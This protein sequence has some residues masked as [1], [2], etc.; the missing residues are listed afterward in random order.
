MSDSQVRPVPLQFGCPFLECVRW[1]CRIAGSVLWQGL[2]RWGRNPKAFLCCQHHNPALWFLYQ[3]DLATAASKPFSFHNFLKGLNYISFPPALP[4]SYD[5]KGRRNG[6]CFSV[7]KKTRGTFEFSWQ[8]RVCPS[9]AKPFFTLERG[10]TAGLM[11]FQSWRVLQ[12]FAWMGK[13]FALVFGMRKICV[14]LPSFHPI[15]VPY[16]SLHKIFKL[17]NVLWLTRRH[18]FWAFGKV[19]VA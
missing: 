1:E 8:I 9:L 18:S 13:V 6:K 7:K 10:K 3:P 2:F 11:V 17:L 15:C 12:P 16:P 5:L 19:S 14:P 4:A